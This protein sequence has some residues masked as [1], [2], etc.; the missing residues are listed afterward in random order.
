MSTYFSIFIILTAP[1]LSYGFNV[2]RDVFLDIDLT[3]I[4]Y[5]QCS[6]L[7]AEDSDVHNF[8]VIRT[9]NTYAPFRLIGLC[10]TEPELLFPHGVN[11]E[12]FQKYKDNDVVA[13]PE[14]VVFRLSRIRVRFS[15][16]KMQVPHIFR[17]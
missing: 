4:F 2:W 15:S 16:V 12:L 13:R 17:R 9:A 6:N 3:F 5:P 14:A 1:I 8:Q 7:L 11:A 10:S